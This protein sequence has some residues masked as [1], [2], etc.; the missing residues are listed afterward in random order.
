MV[1]VL[2]WAGERLAL[3][4]VMVELIFALLPRIDRESYA[5]GSSKGSRVGHLKASAR[6]D[7][8]VEYIVGLDLE[9]PAADGS[10]T[11]DN[12]LGVREL[13]I[14]RVAAV[15]RKSC[16]TSMAQ[17]KDLRYEQ[18]SVNMVSAMF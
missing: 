15:S 4:L 13:K 10:Y 16:L 8:V 1:S 14:F 18:A 9:G 17:D 11:E 6:T 2:V 7:A 12:I 5:G 3:V